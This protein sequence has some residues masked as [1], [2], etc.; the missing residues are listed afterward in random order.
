MKR[1]RVY[2][3]SHHHDIY[4]EDFE[5][6]SKHILYKQH[7]TYYPTAYYN[8]RFYQALDTLPP[9]RQNLRLKSCRV[10]HVSSLVLILMF[11]I[12]IY[13]YNIFYI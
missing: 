10:S 12:N 3:V 8:A 5:S 2:D 1:A 6:V 11:S 13:I 7:A 9:I 4:Y